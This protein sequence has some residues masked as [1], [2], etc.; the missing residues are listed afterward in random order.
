[1]GLSE[2]DANPYRHAYGDYTHDSPNGRYHFE[3]T[4][5]RPAIESWGNAEHY[6][7]KAIE[8]LAEARKLPGFGL[9]GLGDEHQHMM[10]ALE[11][12]MGDAQD[13]QVAVGRL[14]QAMQVANDDYARA[15]EASLAQYQQLM[16]IV[17]L[18]RQGQTFTR[19]D[20][21]A[22]EIADERKL[23][24]DIRPFDPDHPY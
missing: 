4:P 14:V 18:V 11:V 1:M 12:L 16:G 24:Q 8:D 3:W 20:R 6:L 23:D 7:K 22:V 9:N 13:T 19:A 15:N 5:F 10:G 21:D 17:D 2:D